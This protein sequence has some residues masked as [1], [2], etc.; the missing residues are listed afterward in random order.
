[1]FSVQ[2]TTAV[3]VATTLL[4]NEDRFIMN[5]ADEIEKE[6]LELFERSSLQ[7]FA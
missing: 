6:N 3:D 5:P 2:L 4:Y 1:M 7:M